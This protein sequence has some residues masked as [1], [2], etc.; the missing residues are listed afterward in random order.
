MAAGLWALAFIYGQT[1]A[2]NQVC[3]L[4][5]T[6]LLPPVLPSPISAEHRGPRASRARFLPTSPAPTSPHEHSSRAGTQIFAPSSFQKHKAP[7]FYF[8]FSQPEQPMCQ[9][10]ACNRPPNQPICLSSIF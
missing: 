8:Y 5:V 10:T 6:L 7:I 1:R 3:Y 4:T 9:S 2:F